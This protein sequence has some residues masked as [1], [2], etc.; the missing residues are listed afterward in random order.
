MADLRVCFEEMG[1]ENVQTYIQSG[2]VL[3]AASEKDTAKLE[4]KIEKQLSKTFDYNGI[5]VVVTEEKLKEAVDKAP[6]GFGTEPD[7][8][9][10][11]VIFLKDPM[12]PAE[13]MKG[14]RIREGVDQV[15]KGKSVLY[16]SRLISKVSQSY[17]N[18]VVGTP[19][20]K[21]M[22]IRNWRTTCRVGEM[23]GNV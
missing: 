20:Y 4:T 7:K 22:T 16:F 5:V 17:I 11:D 10:Y 8:Y 13:A 3:F 23:V 9:R 15:Y 1:F 6:K 21:F 2:N 12:T 19:V 18:K 14:I